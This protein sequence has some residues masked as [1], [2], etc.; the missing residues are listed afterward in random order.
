MAANE[1]RGDARDDL[2]GH[3]STH[4]RNRGRHARVEP[5][6]CRET[7]NAVTTH[8]RHV[9]TLAIEAEGLTKRFGATCAVDGVDLEVRAGSVYGFLGPNGAGK[10]T[11]IR[12]LATLLRPDAGYARGFGHDV[13]DE[14]DIVRHKLGLTSQFASVDE[15]LTGFENLTLLARLLGYSR[16][17]ARTRAGEL[18][19]AFTL[20]DAADRSVAT[21]SG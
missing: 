5:T 10:T 3:R 9:G 13:V 17:S 7:V 20:V 14:A 6:R 1:P 21:L 15:D 18:L 12:I 16:R 4:G 19:E 2:R 8:S 11:S